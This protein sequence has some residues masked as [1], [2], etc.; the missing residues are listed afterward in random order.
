[1]THDKSFGKTSNMAL[2][3]AYTSRMYWGV[4]L[5]MLV[6]FESVSWSKAVQDEVLR[7]CE[8]V[9]EVRTEAAGAALGI[10]PGNPTWLTTRTMRRVRVARG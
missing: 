3:D 6:R 9:V 10:T 4:C 8:E 5:L 1:M 2:L 7:V